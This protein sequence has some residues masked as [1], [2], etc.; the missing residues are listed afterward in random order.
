MEQ[1]IYQFKEEYFSEK[2]NDTVYVLL[3]EKIKENLIN[4]ISSKIENLIINIKEKFQSNQRCIKRKK[5]SIKKTKKIF[6][7][8]PPANLINEN[9]NENLVDFSPIENQLKR[10]ILREKKDIFIESIKNQIETLK[11]NDSYSINY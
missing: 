7:S 5:R 9:K 1:A 4:Y 10:I 11:S 3:M 6:D 8:A 2:E